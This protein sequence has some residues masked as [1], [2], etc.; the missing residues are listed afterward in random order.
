MLRTQ[1]QTSLFLDAVSIG[2]VNTKVVT[3]RLQRVMNAAARVLSSTH[4]Y[5]RGL[6]RL[7]HSID[8]SF[9]GS[10]CRKEFSTNSASLCTVACTANHRVTSQISVYQCPTSQQNSIFDPLLGAS[11]WFRDAGSAHSVHGPSLWPARRFGTL[12][13]TAW[14]IRILAWTTADVCWRRIYFHCT[15]ALS[16][17]EML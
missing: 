10:M 4:K 9:I 6:S 1:L 15:E 3:D 2:N 7:L 12:Y 14:V 5:D 13:H 11:W 8:Q 17:L 16:V